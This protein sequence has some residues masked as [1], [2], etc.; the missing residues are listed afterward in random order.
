MLL[1]LNSVRCSYPEYYQNLLKQSFEDFWQKLLPFTHTSHFFKIGREL[2]IPFKDLNKI[3]M[4]LD[5]KSNHNDISSRN[6]HLLLDERITS[7]PWLR[8]DTIPNNQKLIGFTD[9]L[10]LE[11]LDELMEK[12]FDNPLNYSLEELIYKKDKEEKPII[13]Q[14][15]SL[16]KLRKMTK[17]D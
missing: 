2:G 13:E 17:F 7:I 3:I 4:H 8:I 15:I 12:P 11:L 6:L 9:I 10:R 1:F 5:D 14:W 16:R